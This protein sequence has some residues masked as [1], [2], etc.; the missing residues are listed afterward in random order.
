MAAEN[1][2]PNTP[3]DSGPGTTAP[4]AGAPA[5]NATAMPASPDAPSGA[6]LETAAPDM[7]RENAATAP[8]GMAPNTPAPGAEPAVAA[9]SSA[10]SVAA[11]ATAEGVATGGESATGAQAAGDDNV[12]SLE[13]LIAETATSAA[14][15]T[16]ERA[17]ALIDKVLEVE[18]PAFTQELKALKEAGAPQESDV[19]VDS[20]VDQLVE[21]EKKE[22]AAKGAKRLRLLLLVRPWRKFIKILSSLK[23]VWP[24]LRYT[25]FPAMRAGAQK[26][27]A[28]LKTGAGWLIGKIKGAILWFSHQPRT[29]KLLLI[30]V[31]ALATAAIVMTRIAITGSFLPSLEKDFLYSF[32]TAADKSYTFGA[33]EK[34]QDLNDPLLHPEHIVLIERLIVNL[35]SP[36]DGSNPMALFDLYVEASSQ[37]AAVE[38]KGR[39]S[40]MRDMILRTM[41]QMTYEELITEA[42]KNKLKIFLRK[43]LND[44]LSKGR[45]RRIF[46]KS[47]VLKP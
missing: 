23:A 22:K 20:D 26:T 16:P 12:L 42:G 41:E 45:I 33:D 25:V 32:A 15:P 1:E 37:D 47:F 35:R 14:A 38:L 36:G 44:L 46:F 34:W 43:N 28:G 5:A 19:A 6:S 30:A 24:W 4:T 31:A 2:A 40:E 13:D 3:P 9:G 10:G 21:N 27:F 18:D 8:L 39:D 11:N 17:T 29:S 7:P